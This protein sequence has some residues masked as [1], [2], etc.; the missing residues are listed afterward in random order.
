MESSDPIGEEGGVNLYGFVGNNGVSRVDYVGYAYTTVSD[1][2][3]V[4]SDRRSQY[5]DSELV[6]AIK[7]DGLLVKLR[8]LASYYT[9]GSPS[10]VSTYSN[11]VIR[12]SASANE[13]T[14]VHELTH[15]Y[16]DLTPTGISYASW[17]DEGMAWTV[18]DALSHLDYLK[19]M[20]EAIN[21]ADN[22]TIVTT[23]KNE[24]WNY[25]DYSYTYSKWGQK[26]RVS[27]ILP[28]QSKDLDRT[29]FVNVK[30]HLG[31]NFSCSVIANALN[32]ILSSKGYRN[33]CIR[34]SCGPPAEKSAT[35]EA[36]AVITIGTNQAIEMEY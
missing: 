16:N 25:W 34:V 6:K 36:G 8:G 5:S 30:T 15:A 10:A 27:A 28:D 9:V 19:Q 33:P 11:G 26:T 20:E 12:F 21:M 17:E 13:G 18:S 23:L 14:V 4:I 3:H 22:T 2:N 31:A 7:Y 24:W 1:V 29:D 35:G 32:K